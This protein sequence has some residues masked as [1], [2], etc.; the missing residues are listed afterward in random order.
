MRRGTACLAGLVFSVVL[1]SASFGQ[2]DPR[3]KR[4]NPDCPSWAIFGLEMYSRISVGQARVSPSANASHTEFGESL[5]NEVGARLLFPIGPSFTLALGG[6]GLFGVR[7]YTVTER[8]G[9]LMD[10]SY[11]RK[12]RFVTASLRLYVPRRG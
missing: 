1:S 10:H 6:G 12:S 5:G 2:A 7:D 3:V 8:F 9:Y 11:L 4:E